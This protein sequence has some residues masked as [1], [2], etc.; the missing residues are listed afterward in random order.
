MRRNSCGSL[1]V[2][3]NNSPAPSDTTDLSPPVSPQ[4]LNKEEIIKALEPIQKVVGHKRAMDAAEEQGERVKEAETSG[5]ESVLAI[6]EG[7][8]PPQKVQISE[9]DDGS[10]K[11]VI[12]KSPKHKT[13]F[14]H[15]IRSPKSNPAPLFRG[16]SG[17]NEK[18]NYT[19]DS[20]T[21]LPAVLKIHILNYINPFD[22]RQSA[23][24]SQL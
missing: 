3:P 8:E 20:R 13:D 10:T 23:I 1:E 14:T 18:G 21:A 22:L 2:L 24:F 19:T 16:V 15:K 9:T 4:Y 12:S 17:P 7:G 11:Q 6:M 5:F